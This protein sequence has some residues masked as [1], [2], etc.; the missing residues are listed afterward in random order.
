MSVLKEDEVLTDGVLSGELRPR[1][2]Q[3]RRE[4]FTVFFV[5]RHDIDPKLSGYCFSFKHFFFFELAFEISSVDGTGTAKNR[6]WGG[7]LCVMEEETDDVFARNGCDAARR[8]WL[9]PN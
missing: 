7:G 1:D 9:L 3:F 8:R 4:R 5:L 2:E 6:C